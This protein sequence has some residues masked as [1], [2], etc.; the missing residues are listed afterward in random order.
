MNAD[1]SAVSQNVPA[2]SQRSRLQQASKYG[3][4]EVERYTK[5]DPVKQQLPQVLDFTSSLQNSGV[6]GQGLAQQSQGV[7]QQLLGENEK[8]MQFMGQTLANEQYNMRSMDNDVVGQVQHEEYNFKRSSTKVNNLRGSQ[9]TPRTPGSPDIGNDLLDKNDARPEGSRSPSHLEK[10]KPIADGPGRDLRLLPHSNDKLSASQI[11]KS[12]G[13]LKLGQVGL[14]R[15]RDTIDPNDVLVA[16]LQGR[17]FKS[18]KKSQQD[19]GLSDELNEAYYG[20]YAAKG[21]Q[22][23]GIRK[24][25]NHQLPFAQ[26]KLPFAQ[27]VERQYLDGFIAS[28]PKP[29][30]HPMQVLS[31]SEQSNASHKKIDDSPR[32]KDDMNYTK[33][34]LK[35]NTED[36]G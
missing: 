25:S 32:I 29:I 11:K 10:R 35:Y 15:G 16:G 31:P 12:S 34:G 36:S 21:S 30:K 7:S 18:Q 14:A 4:V 33:S 20:S 28:S 27:V 5:T 3:D 22:G 1:A 6:V 8:A 24:H 13:T 2:Q 26:D 23:L 17:T 9:R 19:Q